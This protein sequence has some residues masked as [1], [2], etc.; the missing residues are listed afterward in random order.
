MDWAIIGTLIA[1]CGVGIA[2]VAQL[3]RALHRFELHV[4]RQTELGC[5]VEALTETV[6]EL[7]Q[8]TR[9]LKGVLKN[10]LNARLERLDG[11][12]RMQEERCKSNVSRIHDRL[13]RIER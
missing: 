10:G 9:E 6:D 1:A 5:T 12:L 8:D 11:A 7:R 4:Q 3:G 13:D 2:F